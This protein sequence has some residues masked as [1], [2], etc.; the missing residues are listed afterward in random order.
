MHLQ[1][2]GPP[3]LEDACYGRVG[4]MRLFQGQ[5]DALLSVRTKPRV[6]NFAVPNFRFHPL[7][8]TATIVGTLALCLFHGHNSAIR[9]EWE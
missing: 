7:S 4:V 6:D 9:P 5:N 3:R 1:S 2:T 8:Y